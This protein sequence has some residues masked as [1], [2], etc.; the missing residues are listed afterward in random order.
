[1]PASTG[2]R[3]HVLL[4]SL[5]ASGA[6]TCTP[7]DAGDETTPSTSS[8][9]D[10]SVSEGSAAPSTGS[11]D[12]TSTPTS[13]TTSTTDSSSSGTDSGPA[14]TCEI[15]DSDCT[16]GLPVDCDHPEMF[17]DHACGPAGR[18]DESGCLRRPCESH[19][20]CDPGS[21]CHVPAACDPDV[22]ISSSLYCSPEP[23]GE[24]T[25]GAPGDCTSTQGWCVPDQD[26]PKC[27]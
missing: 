6:L 13:G 9:T 20:D 21:G 14:V 17:F 27:E 19:A 23:G 2:T 15:W 8:A 12:T 5:L 22:C 3:R 7:G 4:L 16:C 10:V 18:F 1:M 26:R 25:W 24:C 11:G